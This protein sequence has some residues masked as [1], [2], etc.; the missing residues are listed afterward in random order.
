[1]G[2]N[3]CCYP[4]RFRLTKPPKSRQ[5]AMPHT[6]IAPSIPASNSLRI[7]ELRKL[8][9]FESAYNGAFSIVAYATNRYLIDHLL[10]V[11]RVLTD[12]D[13]EAMVIWGV[14]AH[15]GVA[16]LMPPGVLP[17]AVLDERGRFGENDHLIK[18]MRLRDIAQITGIPRETTRRKLAMLADK[19]Y[20]SKV[21]QGWVISSERTEPDLRDFTRESVMRLLAVADEIMAALRDADARAGL[22]PTASATNSA[23]L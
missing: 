17:S 15:Q 6:P 1:M 3:F 14:L 16:H 7:P 11:G 12:N 13:Y 10:R 4:A 9:N 20:I 19:K 18:P 2:L 23:P 5:T 8:K 21:T 22:P